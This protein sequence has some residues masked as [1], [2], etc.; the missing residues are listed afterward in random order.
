[1]KYNSW[2][3]WEWW[4][5][6]LSQAQAWLS[7]GWGPSSGCHRRIRSFNTTYWLLK[8]GQ[9]SKLSEPRFPHLWFFFFGCI[10]IQLIFS[11]CTALWQLMYYQW[12]SEIAESCLTLWDPM[13]CTHQA[14]PSIAFSRKEYWSEL[15]FPSPHSTSFVMYIIIFPGGSGGKESACNAGDLGSFP[16]LEISPGGGHDNPLQYSC[17]ENP[18]AGY[19]PWDHK[20]SDTTEQLSTQH[21]TSFK[22]V[23]IQKLPV[24]R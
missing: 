1:M 21:S 8:R 17:Q 20:E 14:P 11:S 3:C 7:N 5:Y 16:R 10:V 15:P 13:D 2:K 19:S 12:T 6:W 18:M 23:K 4:W 22:V 24:T 9:V